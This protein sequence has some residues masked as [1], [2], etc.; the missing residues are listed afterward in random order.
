MLTNNI[1]FI[2][3]VF[4]VYMKKGL[5]KKER[6]AEIICI[7]D[8]IKM[9]LSSLLW[10]SRNFSGNHCYKEKSKPASSM[11]TI[12]IY[13]PEEVFLFFFRDWLILR[14]CLEYSELL[15]F[16]LERSVAMKEDTSWPLSPRLRPLQR[17]CWQIESESSFPLERKLILFIFFL[18]SFCLWINW[19]VISLYRNENFRLV[20]TSPVLK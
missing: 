17:A 1:S 16:C 14:F 15:F 13:L 10:G 6:M 4:Y 2:V 7:I 5:L 12:L 18:S 19:S 11:F 20:R 3:C 8:C 9:S